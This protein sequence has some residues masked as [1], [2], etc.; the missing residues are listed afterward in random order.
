[1]VLSVG[2][3]A[4]AREQKLLWLVDLLYGVVM[5][6]LLF[7]SCFSV[8]TQRSIEGQEGASLCY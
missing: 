4:L 8:P 3:R 5:V 2:V 1:M 7:Q 6:D